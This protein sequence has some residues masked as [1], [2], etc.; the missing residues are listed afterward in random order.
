MPADVMQAS[1]GETRQDSV[2]NGL[3]ALA[4][5]APGR[6]LIHDGVRPFVS[7]ALIDRVMGAL[8]GADAVAPMLPVTDTLRRKTDGGFSIVPRERS[9]ARADAPGISL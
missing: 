4:A 6:V 3:E 7:A 8:D 5:H 9:A 1:G 2:R